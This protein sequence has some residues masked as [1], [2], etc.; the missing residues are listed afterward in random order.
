MFVQGL[1]PQPSHTSYVSDE[2]EVVLED[3]NARIRLIFNELAA[4]K[5]LNLASLATGACTLYMVCVVATP[6]SP[7]SRG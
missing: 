1:L 6:T 3:S 5:G 4:A 2:D 7:A